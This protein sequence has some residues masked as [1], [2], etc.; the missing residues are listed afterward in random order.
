VLVFDPSFA[1]YLLSFAWVANR[2]IPRIRNETPH[3]ERTRCREA[4]RC[5]L[6]DIRRNIPAEFEY[7]QP[8]CPLASLH[9]RRKDVRRS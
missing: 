6:L 3:D 8:L 2:K 1:E 7:C 5:G 9:L 4:V